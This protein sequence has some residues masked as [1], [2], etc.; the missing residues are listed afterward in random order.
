L[1]SD[2]RGDAHDAAADDQDVRAHIRDG[3]VTAA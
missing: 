1:A 3:P 2:R